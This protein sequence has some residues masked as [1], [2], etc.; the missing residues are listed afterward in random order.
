MTK[1]EK[2]Q[3]VEDVVPN[4][5]KNDAQQEKTSKKTDSNSDKVALDE[6]QQD[7]AVLVQK[8]EEL[9]EQ[10]KRSQ[11][12]FQNY[13]RRVQEQQ[14]QNQ[15]YSTESILQKF[16]PIYDNFQLA[17]MH[18]ENPAQC[19]A[20]IKMIQQQFWDILANEGIT[21]HSLVGKPFDPK[22]AEAIQTTTDETQDDNVVV[23]EITKGYMMHDKVIRHAKVVVNKRD[24]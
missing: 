11:A 15:K 1:N 8:I 20:G 24:K 5:S 14:Q 23:K 13:Q 16:I 12:D 2:K 17:M 4:Q 3:S 21:T 18:T 10:L 22:I 9:T 19:V 6:S 7:E